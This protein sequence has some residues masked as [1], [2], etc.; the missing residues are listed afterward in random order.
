MA[1]TIRGQTV[2]HEISRK[3]KSRE[4]EIKERE[5]KKRRCARHANI[6]KSE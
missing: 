4:F 6:Q 1:K 3:K 5:K 2:F